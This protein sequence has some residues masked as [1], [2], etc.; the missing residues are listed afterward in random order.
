MTHQ[1]HK[2]AREMT[3]QSFFAQSLTVFDRVW[4]AQDHVESSAKLRRFFGGRD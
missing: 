2:K 3:G 4:R 1:L